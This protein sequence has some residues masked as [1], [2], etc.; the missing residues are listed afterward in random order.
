MTRQYVKIYCCGDC[1]HYNWKKHK[2]TLGAKEYDG[3]SSFY[4]DCPLGI[5]EEEVQEDDF[6]ENMNQP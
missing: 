6:A 5:C 2:C 3:K 4:A 1:I